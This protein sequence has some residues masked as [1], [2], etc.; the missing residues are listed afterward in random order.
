VP[1]QVA[2]HILAGISAAVEACQRACAAPFGA[3]TLGPA[4]RIATAKAAY[5]VTPLPWR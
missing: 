3:A 2:T 5:S 1:A 4:S